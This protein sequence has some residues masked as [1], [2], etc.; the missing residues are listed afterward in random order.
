MINLENDQLAFR[1]PEVHEKAACT[2][3]FQRTLRI[4]DDGADYP[5][6]AG[7]GKF[8][9]RHLEDFAQ[10]VPEKWLAKGG[11]IMPMHQAEAMWISFKSSYPFAVRI[12]AGKVCA[13]TGKPWRD[14]PSRSS[15]DYVVLPEQPWLD[16]YCVGRGVI[17]QFVAMPLGSG[18][19]A[20]EQITGAADH[21]GIQI[22]VYPMKKKRYEKLKEEQRELDRRIQEPMFAMCLVEPMALAPGGRM[23]QEIAADEHGGKAWDHDH[24]SR[25]FV[26]IVNSTEWASVTGTRPPTKSPTAKEYSDSGLPWFE[27]YGGDAAAMEGAEILANLNSVAAMGKLKGETPLPENESIEVDNTLAIRTSN[28][29]IVREMNT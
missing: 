17:R 12:A 21:G 6:P 1:F 26:S 23:V 8:P 5:L 28:S 22:A 10:Q 2:V 14:Y 15:Q 19:S 29:Q 18:Y 25:C 9:L 4:P 24:F 7:L 27:Y 11:V 16:G 3:E 13:V 20:E